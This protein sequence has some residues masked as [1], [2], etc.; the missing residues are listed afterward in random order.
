MD[1]LTLSNATI[2]A[3]VLAASSSDDESEVFCLWNCVL[4]LVGLDVP[5]GYS[6]TA[7]KRLDNRGKKSSRADLIVRVILSGVIVM[8]VECKSIAHDNLID[9]NTT[10]E[11][12][13]EYLQKAHCRNGV[14]AIGHKCKFYHISD[15]FVPHEREY[16]WIRD[17]PDIIERLVS[18][19]RTLSFQ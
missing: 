12:L 5:H 3:L 11:Q 6:I 18:F 10:E 2:R 19:T 17:F 4:P 7:E 13:N 14:I 16:D 8:I 9:W 15:R 1:Q